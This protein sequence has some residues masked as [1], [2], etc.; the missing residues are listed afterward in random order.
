[1]SI[2]HH[3]DALNPEQPLGMNQGLRDKQVKVFNFIGSFDQLTLCYQ[4]PDF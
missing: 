1:M 2:F 4:N 3:P